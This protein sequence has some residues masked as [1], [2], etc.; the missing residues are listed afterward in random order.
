MH[1]STNLNLFNWI[2]VNC[3]YSQEQQ[4]FEESGVKRSDLILVELEVPYISR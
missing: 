4:V 2:I 1:V 3:T